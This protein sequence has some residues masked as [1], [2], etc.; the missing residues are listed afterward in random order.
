M[1]ILLIRY[2]AAF[3]SGW[4]RSCSEAGS[5]AHSEAAR[6]VPWVAQPEAS[7]EDRETAVQAAGL[8]ETEIQRLQE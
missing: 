2:G 1:R 8:R 7:R 5:E 4:R 6:A 3:C